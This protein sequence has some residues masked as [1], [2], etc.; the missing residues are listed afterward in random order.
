MIEKIYKYTI[1]MEDRV[2]IPISDGEILSIINQ[3]ED[4]VMYVLTNDE[5]IKA[6]KERFIDIAVVG[7][8]HSR[9][10]LKGFTYFSTVPF[11]EGKMVFHYFI[12]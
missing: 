12:K 4:A 7:T 6:N 3:N 5:L 9:E 1:P 10:D 2:T 8:G 11:L